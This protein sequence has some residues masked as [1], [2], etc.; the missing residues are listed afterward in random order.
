MEG[1]FGSSAKRQRRGEGTAIRRGGSRFSLVRAE[2]TTPIIIIIIIN[3]LAEDLGDA[4]EL[5]VV[6]LRGGDRERN[7]P[8]GARRNLLACS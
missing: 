4:Q 2:E 1:A 5:R 8:S 3:R 7:G 6:A